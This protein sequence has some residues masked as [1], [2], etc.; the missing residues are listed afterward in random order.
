MFQ[1]LVELDIESGMRWGE[2][3]ELRPRD[4][5]LTTGIVTISRAVVEVNP[6][7]HPTG[8]RFLVQ[9]YPKDKEYRRFKIGN[10]VS[11]RLAGF[12]LNQGLG[13]DNLI[14][15]MPEQAEPA[16]RVEPPADP[17]ELGLTEPNEKGRQYNHGT[18]TAYSMAPSR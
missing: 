18:I 10:E 14:F 4:F 12:I 9:E 17:E 7:D 5:N 8:G 11:R 6:Q 1:L 15:R 16:T 2:L 3:T 13:P